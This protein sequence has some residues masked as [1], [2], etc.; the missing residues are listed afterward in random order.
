MRHFIPPRVLA[1]MEHNYL[2]SHMADVQIL[3]TMLANT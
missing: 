3:C 2:E 1:F